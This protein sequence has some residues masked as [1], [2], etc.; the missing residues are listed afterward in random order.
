MRTILWLALALGACGD[1]D[2]GS[3]AAR[4]AE[5]GDGDA[6]RGDG[7]ANDADAMPSAVRPLTMRERAAIEAQI[8]FELETMSVVV[9]TSRSGAT[10][11]TVL[12]RPAFGPRYFTNDML[13]VVTPEAPSG[14]RVGSSMFELDTAFADYA[15]NAQYEYTW[16]G[17]VGTHA[18]TMRA[19]LVPVPTF[20]LDRSMFEPRDELVAIRAHE[21]DVVVVAQAAGFRFT[22]TSSKDFDLIADGEVVHMSHLDTTIV[23]A[24]PFEGGA[25]V[26]HLTY[27]ARYDAIRASGLR[28][29]LEIGEEGMASGV[30]SLD[31]AIAGIRGAP[32][33]MDPTP[34]EIVWNGEPGDVPSGCTPDCDERACGRDPSCGTDCGACTGLCDPLGMC[35]PPD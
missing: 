8:G 4:D 25:T 19:Q 15:P 1:D 27:D 2:S 31:H 26:Q 7:D 5:V 14:C 9:S 30:I 22:R 28:V 12:I 20:H 3:D 23:D 33:A 6:T 21:E 32:N 11:H 17:N 34:L 18:G 35:L 16:E 13:C 29:Y 10:E 24:V